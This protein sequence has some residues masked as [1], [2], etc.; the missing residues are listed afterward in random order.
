MKNNSFNKEK[1]FLRMCKGYSHV[2]NKWFILLL[3]VAFAAGCKKV[4]E[5]TGFTS[6]CPTVV[7]TIAAVD[8]NFSVET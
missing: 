2:F 8:I 7:S 5:E 4:I 3:L 1:G 6:L